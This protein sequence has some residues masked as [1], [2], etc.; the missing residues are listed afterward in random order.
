MTNNSSNQKF[1][2]NS[3][4][5]T[6]GGGTTERDLTLSSGSITLDGGGSNT[7]TFPGS[8]DTL[9]GRASTD[10]LTNKTFDGTSTIPANAL[11]LGLY[12]GGIYYDGGGTITYTMTG[13]YATVTGLTTATV[14]V[15]SSGIVM[16][17]GTVRLQQSG[18]HSIDMK[19]TIYAGTSTAPSYPTAGEIQ[20]TAYSATTN[21]AANNSVFFLWTGLTPGSTTFT[22][23]A[24]CTSASDATVDN[25]RT[26]ISIVPLIS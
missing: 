24:L 6:I 22:A 7:Y 12:S 18:A 23:K 9:V 3:D 4:G 17:I 10:T 5:F 19:F 2:N 8:T 1:T 25:T 16:A 14:T 15:P 26:F 20:S 11:S 13:S 21:M